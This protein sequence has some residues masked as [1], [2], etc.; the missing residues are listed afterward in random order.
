MLHGASALAIPAMAAVI[1]QLRWTA[2][3][4]ALTLSFCA[5]T[6]AVPLPVP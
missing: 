6:Q 1:A 3:V 2:A 5:D 4:V